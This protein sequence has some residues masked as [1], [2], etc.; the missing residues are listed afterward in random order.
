[1]LKINHPYYKTY[2]VTLISTLELEEG[3]ETDLKQPLIFVNRKGERVERINTRDKFDDRQ[4]RDPSNFVRRVSKIW[5]SSP[6]QC[7][8]EIYIKSL[9][10][11]GIEGEIG[12]SRRES[13]RSNLATRLIPSFVLKRSRVG[14]R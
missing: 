5:D 6:F 4:H 14:C 11:G 7:E 1:M 13:I 10:R 3:R 9:Q 12:E 8:S 2:N